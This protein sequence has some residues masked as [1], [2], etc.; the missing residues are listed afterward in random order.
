VSQ[1]YRHLATEADPPETSESNV[2]TED[3]RIIPFS[4]RQL[5]RA[6]YRGEN[7]VDVGHEILDD[8]ALDFKYLYVFDHDQIEGPK[9]RDVLRVKNGERGWDYVRYKYEGYIGGYEVEWARKGDPVYCKP[10]PEALEESEWI[11]IEKMLE[12]VEN[13]AFHQLTTAKLR[14]LE[15]IFVRK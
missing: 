4:D 1:C 11:F 10:L 2:T 3:P 7:R 5:S 13:S 15:L 12:Y 8:L 9:I 14:Q 6:W